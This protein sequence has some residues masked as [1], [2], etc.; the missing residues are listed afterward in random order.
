[1]FRQLISSKSP[2]GNFRGLT[3]LSTFTKVVLKFKLGNIGSCRSKRPST[4]FSSHS[5]AEY[6][7]SLTE[8]PVRNQLTIAMKTQEACNPLLIGWTSRFNSYCAYVHQKYVPPALQ[9][10]SYKKHIWEQIDCRFLWMN[11]RVLEHICIKQTAHVAYLREVMY[12]CC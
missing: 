8:H 4:H 11:E 12:T 5:L 3:V 7:Y 6:R 1:M 2:W 10:F 9:L